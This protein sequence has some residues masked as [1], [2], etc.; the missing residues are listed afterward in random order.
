MTILWFGYTTA[1]PRARQEATQQHI[2][3]QL[4]GK[5]ELALGE[6][7]GTKRAHLRAANAPGLSGAARWVDSALSASQ[8]SPIGQ[9]AVFTCVPPPRHFPTRREKRFAAAYL[10]S[11][12]RCC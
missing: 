2:A 10:L 8:L 1:A 9:E 6:T 7:Q 11:A 12:S 5:Q 3:S 4:G